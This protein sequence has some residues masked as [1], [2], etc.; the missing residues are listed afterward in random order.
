[1][2]HGDRST[3]RAIV[4]ADFDVLF[5]IESDLSTWELREAAPPGPLDRGAWEARIRARLSDAG[6]DGTVRFAIDA[7]GVCVGR[8]ALMAVDGLA[9]HA[10]LSI[11][12]A[13]GARGRG[14]GADALRT[15]TAFAFARRNLRRLHVE[16][17]ATNAAAIA[18]HTKIGFVEEGRRRE[19]AWV[20]GRYEDMLVMGL[21]RDGWP[22]G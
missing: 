7:G 16:V 14:L 20:D 4:P 10:E 21:L 3:L 1:M 18:C 8:C 15:L 22:A 12:L 13:A 5:A 19:H 9:R 17:L 11:A 6:A 2:L